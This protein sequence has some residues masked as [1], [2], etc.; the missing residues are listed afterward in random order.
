MQPR[1][2]WHLAPGE[3]V[4][5]NVLYMKSIQADEVMNSL[6]DSVAELGLQLKPTYPGLIGSKS[7]LSMCG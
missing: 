2:E 5:V 3:A 1:I 4:Y 7:G 6:I